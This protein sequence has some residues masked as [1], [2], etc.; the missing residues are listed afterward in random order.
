MQEKGA[1]CNWGGG[2][3]ACGRSD[4]IS[5]K[6]MFKEVSVSGK[7]KGFIQAYYYSNSVRKKADV[8][9]SLGAGGS[10]VVKLP[11]GTTEFTVLPGYKAPTDPVLKVSAASTNHPDKEIIKYKDPGEPP[12]IIP[13]VWEP[14]K[15]WFPSPVPGG[16]GGKKPDDEDSDHGQQPGGG[17][18]KHVDAKA[19]Y[20]D[21]DDVYQVTYKGWSP[22]V[23]W[24]QL[25][26]EDHTG[27]YDSEPYEKKPTGSHFLTCNGN[28]QLRFFDK[29]GQMVGKTDTIK[30]TEIKNP[31]C[32][33][34]AGDPTGGGDDGGSS[35][36]D[37][38]CGDICE[39]LKCPGWEDI[40]DMIGGAVAD[41]LPPPPDWEEVAETFGDELVPRL[42]DEMYKQ[43]DDLLG[44]PEKPRKLEEPPAPK[45]DGGVDVPKAEDSV[46]NVQHYDFENVPSVQVNPDNTGGID[47]RMADPIDSIPHT[48]D[49]YKPRPGKE[50]GG[51]LPKPRTD[52]IPVPEGNSLNPSP[53]PEPRPTPK[54]GTDTNV[55][56]P[57]KTLE[58]PP[59]PEMPMPEKGG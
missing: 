34:F 9:F 41:H 16:G 30:T 23:A 28:Y 33:S 59:R 47:L 2:K 46:K 53:P 24:Y 22:D 58:P 10:T 7:G 15:G 4:T 55:P 50:T 37:G 19:R 54:P 35:G 48:E 3:V 44:H 26:F 31:S 18:S 56:I 49:G 27:S 42:G 6:Y 36:G 32:S 12:T 40:A 43:F 11:E 5:K 45:F 17:E 14:D 8:P 51:I 20:K 25:H 21:A 29:S 1:L 39:A 38:M 52:P 57:A 13:G